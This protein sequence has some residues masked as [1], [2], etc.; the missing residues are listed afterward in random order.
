MPFAA[1]VAIRS[2]ICGYT[3]MY[4]ST[5]LLPIRCFPPTGAASARALVC[6]AY[7]VSSASVWPAASEAPQTNDAFVRRWL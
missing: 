4:E 7:S 2:L 1:R 6:R 3:R 5:S